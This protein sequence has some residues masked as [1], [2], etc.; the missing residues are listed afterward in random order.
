MD[1]NPE[2]I[3]HWINKSLSVSEIRSTVLLFLL[4]FVDVFM[5]IPLFMGKA[6]R[7]YFSLLLPPILL[8]HLWGLWIML[9]PYRR[10]IDYHLYIGV[11]CAFLPIGYT[12]VSLQLMY[13]AIGVSTPL[14]AILL[15][16][17]QIFAFYALYKWHFK[18]LATGY[19]YNVDQG[20]ISQNNLVKFILL[21]SI[22]VFLGDLIIGYSHG[23][24]TLGAFV[25]VLLIFGLLL[26][27][28]SV[29]IHKYILIRR[30]MDWV[31]LE[32]PPH[33]K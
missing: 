31:E 22:G 6:D 17:L 23:A 24:A 26:G 3:K 9:E 18:N 12:A 30:H 32:E 15:I 16:A 13:G 8:L 25:G 5:I 21:G 1:S 19:Y 10:Q 4:F 27:M 33:N 28:M 14:Y 29:S 2:Y 20:V 11:L 7:L